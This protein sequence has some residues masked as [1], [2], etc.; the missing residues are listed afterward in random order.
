MS[1]TFVADSTVDG[2]SD[3]TLIIFVNA[4]GTISVDPE[5]LNRLLA[6]QHHTSGVSVVRLGQSD[7]QNEDASESSDCSDVNL[8]VEGFYPPGSAA[9]SSVSS[10]SADSTVLQ[11]TDNAPLTTIEGPLS[12][13]DVLVDPFSE[14]DPDQLKS[15]ENALQSEHAKQILGENVTAM[16]G[17]LKVEGESHFNYSIR[18]DH[19]Y[20]K[21]SAP[22]GTP[23]PAPAPAPAPA[24]P[25]MVV[26]AAPLQALQVTSV[27]GKGKLK[28]GATSSSSPGVSKTALEVLGGTLVP[29]VRP[30]TLPAGTTHVG[31]TQTITNLPKGQRLILPQN[32]FIIAQDLA[33][34]TIATTLET[35]KKKTTSVGGRTIRG[36]K[37]GPE[38][39]KATAGRGKGGAP[40]RRQNSQKISDDLLAATLEALQTSPPVESTTIAAAVHKPTD[41]P[42]APKKMT[43]KMIK[44]SPAE[45]SKKASGEAKK[46]P[47]QTKL[48]EHLK[49]IQPKPKAKPTAEVAA[50]ST[51]PVP[52]PVPVTP[53][54]VSP[55]TPTT[56]TQQPTIS[57]S[58]TSTPERVDGVDLSSQQLK[59]YPKREHRKPPAHLAEA[60]GPALFSTPDIIRRVSTD[61]PSPT[62][63]QPGSGDA[64]A[65]ES[66]LHSNHAEHSAQEDLSLEDENLI[67]ED[68]SELQEATQVLAD[69][70]VSG[71]VNIV[72]SSE[73]LSS[74]MVRSDLAHSSDDLVNVSAEQLD[75]SHLPK[76]VFSVPIPME[77]DSS[78][79][80][81]ATDLNVAICSKKNKQPSDGIVVTPTLHSRKL[82]VIELPATRSASKRGSHHKEEPVTPQ[83]QPQV[84]PESKS[85]A[86]SSQK[87]S[88]AIA[89]R[90]HRKS[91]A[92]SKSSVPRLSTSEEDF[93]T[94]DDDE[95]YNSED[96]PD[97]LWC[98]CQK[99]HNNRF[100]ICCDACEEWFHGKCV[101]ITKAIG[102]Q[103][104]QQGVEWKCPN[105]KAKLDQNKPQATSAAIATGSTTTPTSA[106]TGSASAPS[107]KPQGQ[108]KR[109]P[110]PQ[111]SPKP[112]TSP[113]PQATSKPQTTPKPAVQKPDAKAEGKPTDAKADK[114]KESK[115][116][117]QTTLKFH[118]DKNQSQGQSTGAVCCIVCKKSALSDSIYC[119]DECIVKHGEESLEFIN[120]ERGDVSGKTQIDSRVIV[121]ERKTG[122][123][124]AGPNAPLASNLIS[125]L[126]NHPTYEIVR[127]SVLPTSKFY[128]Q[129]KSA[130]KPN[131]PQPSK[132][133]KHSPGPMKQSTLLSKP[134][135]KQIMISPKPPPPKHSKIVLIQPKPQPA[136]VTKGQTAKNEAQAESSPSVSSKKES[137]ESAEHKKTPVPEKKP[138]QKPNQPSVATPKPATPAPKRT[139]RRSSSGKEELKSS[140][141]RR[142]S[143]SESK[144]SRS[145]DSSKPEPIRLNVKKTLNELLLSRVKEAGDIKIE[146]EAILKLAHQI[147]E[148]L[149]AFFKD[150]GTKYKSKY[151]SIVFNIK[152][153]KNLTLFRQVADKTISAQQLVRLSP[154]D[155]ASQELAQWRE[156]EMRHQLEMIKKNELELLHQAKT[157]VMKTHKGEQIIEADELLSSK[158]EASLTELERSL[159]GDNLQLLD[160]STASTKHKLDESSS[161]RE[162]KDRSRHRSISSGSSSR[163]KDSKDV[164]SKDRKK[165]KKHSRKD[166]RRSRSSSRGRKRH[167]SRSNERSSSKSRHSRSKSRHSRSKS[168]HSRSKSRHSRSKSRHSRSKSRHSRSK[169]RHSRSLESKHVEQDYTIE[170]ESL[171]EV[172]S[173]TISPKPEE[174]V[175]SQSPLLDEFVEE[176]LMNIDENELTLNKDIESDLSD[177]EP[178][179]TVNIKTPPYIEEKPVLWRGTLLMNDVAK[180]ETT[181]LEVS[182]DCD[183]LRDDLPTRIEFVGRIPPE[184]VWDYIAK[185]K[186][187]GT[188]QIIV[189]RLEP[190]RDHDK[191]EYLN[192]YTYLSSRNRIG[193]VGKNLDM[194]K[195]FY[196]YPLGSKSPIPQVLLPLDGPGFED[197]RQHLLLGII[198]RTRRHRMSTERDMPPKA[199]VPKVAAPTE[200]SYTPPLPDAGGGSLTPPHPPP[201]T[202]NILENSLPEFEKNKRTLP[203]SKTATIV[204]LSP[205]QD[206]EDGDVP[207]SPGGLDD[208]DVN[209]EDEPYSPGGDDE[210]SRD[211]R[212]LQKRME[213]LNRKIAEETQEI[214][215][216]AQRCT[217]TETIQ[218]TIVVEEVE[219]DEAYSPSRSFTPPPAATTETIPFLDE[220]MSN[221]SL[222][223]NLQEILASIKK[224][225][226]PTKPMTLKLDPI[227]Q[228]YSGEAEVEAYSPEARESEEIDDAPSDVAYT[229][230]AVNVA[231]EEPVAAAKVHRDPRQRVEVTS[232]TTAKTSLSQLTDD[233]LIKKAAEMGFI[234][235]DKPE[236]QKDSMEMEPL[237][238]GIEP[239]E[240]G[241]QFVAPPYVAYQTGPPPIMP[242]MMPPPHM[243]MHANM[244]PSPMA[245]PP[246]FSNPPPPLPALPPPMP[247][248]PP[249][250]MAPPPFPHPAPQPPPAYNSMKNRRDESKKRRNHD[251]SSNSESAKKRGRTSE[252]G[253]DAWKRDTP[254]SSR[255]QRYQATGGNRGFHQRTRGGGNGGKWTNYRD[256]QQRNFSNP[257]PPS[258]ENIQEEWDKEIRNFEQQREQQ[259]QKFKS[260]G[261]RWSKGNRKR[262]YP[263]EDA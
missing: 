226:E 247:P 119:S 95:D 91:S 166:S 185:M 198:V 168:R 162:D 218:Q 111:A 207:Y 256:Y 59:K 34:T 167:R 3:E 189:V 197:S 233:D 179:S 250:I 1:S 188:K 174:V 61:K 232:K 158:P 85:P 263:S 129:S 38:G 187:S 90:A 76:T 150:T 182:G 41:T 139:Q 7:D 68:L 154:E 213:E 113:K 153:P 229:P 249:T 23:S 237:P 163:K 259:R 115:G 209:D 161:K 102:K 84:A 99:P 44:K 205:T 94:D 142:K 145:D 215:S 157:V 159:N 239:E 103:I 82:P 62:T 171:K 33:S 81:D 149:F 106:N 130:A 208:D 26:A 50:D 172:T 16:F 109:S 175:E 212:D 40:L 204:S 75:V 193:V 231:D 104:E 4:D 234:D 17:T 101:G 2:Q 126:K 39:R 118:F 260:G 21:G 254:M 30:L 69:E 27:R 178:S 10:T 121:A 46:G 6:N 202:F 110:K 235:Q 141:Q 124:I 57:S 96:D 173:F 120:K 192:L 45:D 92:E 8:T 9:H 190:E 116:P 128:P 52:V 214:Q 223:K 42:V 186:K 261:K 48:L 60:L 147:E 67:L 15:L 184:T 206:A 83:L 123:L 37:V 160:E 22:T 195:D 64:A 88:A 18:N 155:M 29:L 122:R 258:P 53:D 242:P 146:E 89:T 191:L 80:T 35:P 224:V 196:I 72:T 98:I 257:P 54:Q 225:E 252:E 47:R 36:G 93:I 70:D 43:V 222:P 137:S 131:P 13:G 211:P 11:S 112:Q 135:S 25:D 5:T 180:F 262:K 156:R 71:L 216:M 77:V 245:F 28:V 240:Y 31:A 97:R 164:K 230:S 49:K 114:Q 220:N 241:G 24:P 170:E 138:I 219:E 228:A 66:L 253:N 134:G 79:V 12:G 127:P 133:V 107:A 136:V 55:S 87:T 200:R 244:P 51:T 151:R 243:P 248:P 100:M 132:V 78:K 217:I 140:T 74:E 32:Q 203:S 251:D 108:L 58:A 117:R 181:I 144:P 210:S 152:D 176:Q 227:V 56:T 86:E 201:T 65:P 221:I 194:I 165:D 63:P 125:W 177:R 199:Q 19:C 14:M 20:T 183:Y 246:G 148:E 238:P 105:C 255:G 236:E 143:E 169:S 73:T